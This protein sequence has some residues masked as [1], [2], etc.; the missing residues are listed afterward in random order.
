MVR[1]MNLHK[2][3]EGS[4]GSSF[5]GYLLVEVETQ[6]KEGGTGLHKIIR[7]INLVYKGL[8]CLANLPA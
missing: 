2:T 4:C 1:V 5:S 7:E 6:V 3:S 8:K